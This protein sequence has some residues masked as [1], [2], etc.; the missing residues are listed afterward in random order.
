MPLSIMGIIFAA[1]ISFKCLLT[2]YLAGIVGYGKF[3][4]AA[5]CLVVSVWENTVEEV[6]P[7]LLALAD[8]IGGNAALCDPPVKISFPT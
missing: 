5:T 6:N 8:K 1:Y 2:N 3:A 4:D 7:K